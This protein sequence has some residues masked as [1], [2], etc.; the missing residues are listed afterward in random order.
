MSVEIKT[1]AV[2]PVRQTFSHIARRLGADKPASRYQE[3]TFDLQSDCNFHYRPLWDPEHELYDRR[4]TAIVMK[5]WY[6][7]KDP[8]QFYY[9]AYVLNRSKLQ[10]TAEKNF[11]FVEKHGALAGLPKGLTRRIKAI[12]LP[13]RH[14]E[15]AANLNNCYISAYGW[16]AAVTQA[17]T[18]AM[19]DR[20]GIAQYLS[21]IGLLIDGNTG[22]SLE[23]A[24]QSWMS[25]PV[26]QPLRKLAEDNFVVKDWF[27]LFVAQNLVQD[28][29]LYPLAYGRF[30]GELS[31][32]GG[33]VMAMLTGF[34]DEWYSESV[35]W[36]DAFVKTA[37]A[38]S[39]QNKQQ[40]AAWVGEAGARSVEALAP[41]A[42]L[43]YFDDAQTALD[44]AQAQL[45]ARLVKIGLQA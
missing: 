42:K 36:I 26:W 19:M 3:A 6:A 40:L 5:D 20:L 21:R 17:T 25:D 4:R 22:E 31:Q 2:E 23:R 41:L 39:P 7:F 11:E 28:G 29:L 10:D 9:G 27:E 38:E 37:A 30:G 1:S 44:E 45:R 34:M 33:S 32:S 14:L 16:G 18:Y 35:R 12:L 13:L 8:R 24:K 15:Y 43:M